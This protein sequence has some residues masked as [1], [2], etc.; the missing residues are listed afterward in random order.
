LEATR[1]TLE[2]RYGEG[3]STSPTGEARATTSY[4]SEMETRNRVLKISL[5]MIRF[6]TPE[7]QE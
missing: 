3:T 7:M 2:C 4:F 5:D 6:S 1:I